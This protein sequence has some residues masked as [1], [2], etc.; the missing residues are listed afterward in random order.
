MKKAEFSLRNVL[1]GNIMKIAQKPPGWR[2]CATCVINPGDSLGVCQRQHSIKGR[3]HDLRGKQRPCKPQSR[4]ERGDILTSSPFGVGTGKVC[5][6]CP[7]DAPS[8]STVSV[9]ISVPR[10]MVI[11]T[12]HMVPKVVG[13]AAEAWLQKMGRVAGEQAPRVSE[14]PG[15]VLRGF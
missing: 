8:H 11:H 15:Q 9:P 12:Q 1:Q 4:Y 14:R 2:E 10:K 3:N 7:S 5:P 13:T 6:L